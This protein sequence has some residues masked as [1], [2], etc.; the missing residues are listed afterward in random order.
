MISV[1]PSP[2]ADN[3]QPNRQDLLANLGLSLGFAASLA[4][5]GESALSLLN[6]GMPA[7]CAEYA[8]NVS[9]SEGNFNSVSVVNG[10]AAMVHFSSAIA[11]RCKPIGTVRARIF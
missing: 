6:A 4:F 10:R 8:S 7:G 9:H 5:A 11:G 2:A 3:W 1:A